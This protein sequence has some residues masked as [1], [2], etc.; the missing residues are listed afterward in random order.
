[1]YTHIHVQDRKEAKNSVVRRQPKRQ[2][3][4][5][6][7]FLVVVVPHF[8]AFP[9]FFDDITHLKNTTNDPGTRK[10]VKI[11]VFLLAESRKGIKV[12]RCRDKNDLDQS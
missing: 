4:I 6:Q 7:F 10:K 9:D 12:K 3:V 8:V 5:W 2:E 1:M 11:R